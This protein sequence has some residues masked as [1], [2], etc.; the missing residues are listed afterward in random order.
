MRSTDDQ[1]TND[2]L[3][4]AGQDL[5][6][7]ATEQLDREARQAGISLS[8]LQTMLT[9]LIRGQLT[10]EQAAQELRTGGQ[11]ARID[12]E[13]LSTHG[14]ARQQETQ[15]LWE[16]TDLGMT[17]IRRA[18]RPVI[19]EPHAFT[20]AMSDADVQRS[21][22]AIRQAVAALSRPGA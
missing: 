17:F 5:V 20:E 10:L 8:E 6:R 7:L 3:T 13:N 1:P 2:R 19:G 16:L 9:L 14:L 22:S 11:Q 18:L 15:S 21:S 12:L 4:R